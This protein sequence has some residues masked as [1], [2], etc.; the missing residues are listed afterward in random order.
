MTATHRMRRVYRDGDDH[1]DH[2]PGLPVES[3]DQGDG[4]GDPVHTEEVA[5]DGELEGGSLGVLAL[6]GVDHRPH[7]RVLVH[8]G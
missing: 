6:Q 7:R 5:A 1:I 8:L 3:L 2:V 4:A